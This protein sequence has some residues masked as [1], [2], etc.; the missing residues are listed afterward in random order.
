[1]LTTYFLNF[2]LLFFNFYKKKSQTPTLNVLVHIKK[3]KTP[4]PQK[5][6]CTRP[7]ISKVL[8]LKSIHENPVI[9]NSQKTEYLLKPSDQLYV[10]D[11][12]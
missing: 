7:C 3:I 10:D 8:T 6:F 1:M 5:N 9:K 11:N 2:I 4:Y 12:F